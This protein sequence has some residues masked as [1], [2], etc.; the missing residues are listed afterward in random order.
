MQNLLT[1]DIA[2]GRIDKPTIICV[3]D[4]KEV[5]DTIYQT[6][7]PSVSK[8]FNIETCQS[9]EEA[10]EILRDLKAR[11]KPVAVIISD[12]LMPGMKGD[13]FLIQAHSESPDTVNI[14]LTGEAAVESVGAAINKANLYRFLKKPWEP[15]D[16]VLTVTQGIN[17]Y[18]QTQV[19][20]E[21]NRAVRQLHNAGNTMARLSD[22]GDLIQAATKALLEFTG[23]HRV[24]VVL[25]ND[26]KLVIE[27][28]ADADQAPK[29]LINL[30]L[31]G[32]VE[33]PSTLLHAAAAHNETLVLNNIQQNADFGSDAYLKGRNVK[34]ALVMPVESAGKLS[35]I[36][37]LENL[38]FPEAYT[39]ERLEITEILAQQA[40][41]ALETVYLL[42]NME[43]IIH[44]QTREVV[45]VSSHKD[46]MV[47]IV[48]HDIR[49][50]LT[51]I[52][53]L[54]TMLQDPDKAG[55]KA[56]VIKFAGI[57]SKSV[58]EV[59]NFVNDILDLAKLESGTII[60][61]KTE[62]DLGDMLHKLA[63]SFE[64]LALTKGVQLKVD[65]QTP[66]TLLVDAGKIAQAVNNLLANAFKF[67]NKDGTVTLRL[68]KHQEHGL[69]YAR[70]TVSDTGIGIPEEELP[71]I[72]DK[73][74]KYQRSGTKGEK[75]TGLG[76]NIAKE[77]ITMHDGEIKVESTVG[78]G[79]TF[80]VLLRI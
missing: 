56:Q 13:E 16:L 33:Y 58:K 80:Y 7:E 42:N 37:C 3:D 50:P 20:N 35:A 23:S 65:V 5:L 70:I 51:G 14:M 18:L 68:D 40:A 60:L 78:K 41:A 38:Q 59:L 4:I 44:N 76:M 30:P 55:D 21:H 1:K 9:G 63:N 29:T 15:D 39:P 24:T 69:S 73:F 47:K 71:R 49:S 34:S 64:P 62:T 57:I 79:T 27:G 54:V 8:F 31:N 2:A 26:N 10:L 25:N 74:N 77:L 72:F 52:Q 36:F 19:I 17:A 43:E 46:E 66:I 75:G 45:A 11:K 32:S 53:Q 67:T 61:T 12:H 22:L 48:S 6:I 28:L